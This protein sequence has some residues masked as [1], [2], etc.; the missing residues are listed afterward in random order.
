[1]RNPRMQI[2]HSSRGRLLTA[3]VSST[4]FATAAF[5]HQDE[6]KT[7]T[8]LSGT[9]VDSGTIQ[10]IA[11]AHVV[12]KLGR[13]PQMPSTEEN[14]VA[15]VLTDSGG[16]FHFDSLKPGEHSFVANK[17]GCLHSPVHVIN[18]EAVRISSREVSL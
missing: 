3:V 16:H 4:L 11:N 8:G 2:L 12:L 13:I 17:R 1:M 15:D 9:V 10:P 14:T 7:L 6:R 5:S 18:L